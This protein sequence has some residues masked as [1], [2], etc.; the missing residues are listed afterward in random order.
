M[1]NVKKLSLENESDKFRFK[2]III[3]K[4]LRNICVVTKEDFN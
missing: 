1:K 2:I 4:I 3:S